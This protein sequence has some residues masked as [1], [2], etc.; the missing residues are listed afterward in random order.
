MKRP[1]IAVAAGIAALVLAG[2]AYA[3]DCWDV[4]GTF[5][6]GPPATCPSFLCTEG[7]LSGDLKATYSFVATG[8]NPDGSLSGASTITLRNHMQL[9]GQDTSALGAP[10]PDGTIPFVTTVNL[11][12]GTGK[13][14][15]TSGRIVATGVLSPATGETSGTY[16]GTVC[17]K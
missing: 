16:S 17:K 14:D 4:S 12:D 1:L 5:T 11:V 6:A 2:A 15:D 7:V 10:N 3:K 8:V 13:Y 9:F